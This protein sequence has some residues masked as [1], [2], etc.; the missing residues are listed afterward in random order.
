MSVRAKLP[1]PVPALG[2]DRAREIE[3]ASYLRTRHWRTLRVKALQK[4]EGRCERCGTAKAT[5]VHHRTYDRLG[6]ET[7][8]DL[9]PLCGDCHGLEHGIAA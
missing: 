6:E 2:R 1:A 8:S 7:L 9:E 4:W 3:Y 5:E